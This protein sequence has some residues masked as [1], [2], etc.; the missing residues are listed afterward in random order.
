MDRDPFLAWLDEQ[1]LPR[2]EIYACPYLPGREARQ[3]GFAAERLP[4]ELYHDLMERGYRRNGAIF[5]GMDC[6]TCRA[7]VPL[8]VPVDEFRPSK[9]QRRT[10]N[11]NRDVRVEFRRPQ[12]E[13]QTFELYVRYLRHQ[14]PDTPMQECEQEFRRAFYDRVV[15]S[16]EARYLVGDRLIGVSLLDACSRS[17]SA[18]YHFFEPE[19]RHRR[20]GVLSVLLEIEHARSLG[21]PHYHLGYWIEGA[22]TMHYKADYRPHEVLHDGVWIR[23]G[24][25]RTRGDNDDAPNVPN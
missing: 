8:R 25:R 23:D 4:A 2:T 15:E 24:D 14:H 19:Q 17:L 1:Q 16:L 3:F 5:Y 11:R 13:R 18:V 7:C 21:V 6:P 9:S 10:R 20:I 22:P 12:F